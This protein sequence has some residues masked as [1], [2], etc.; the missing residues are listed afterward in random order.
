M[1]TNST[2]TRRYLA[3]AVLL[4]CF[5]FGAFVS[6]RS[7]SLGLGEKFQF[8]ASRVFSHA[9]WCHNVSTAKGTCTQVDALYP[10]SS[11]NADTWKELGE[12]LGT[13]KFKKL[14]IGK[15]SGLIQIP[16]ESYDN[17]PPP[18]EDPRWETMGQ[19]HDYL[20]EAFPRIHSTL[21]LT[22][23]NTYGLMYEWTGSDTSLK[24]YILAAHQDV[25]P[26]NP[27]T[28]DTWTHPPYSGYFDGTT[29]WGRGASDDKGSLAGIM[30][31]LETLIEKGWTPS[32][33]IVL[34]FGFDEEASGI[35]GASAL[36]KALEETYGRDAFAFVV[37]EGGGFKDMYG[38]IF[39]T[40]GVAEKGYIDVKVD[41][42]SPGGHSS[43]PP[44][45][46]TIGYLA[47]LIAE[48][49]K[50]PYPVELARNTVP[51]DTLLCYA[52]HGDTIPSSLKHAIIKSIHSD[53][54]LRKVDELFV[55][56]DLWYSSL[57]GTTQAV[58]IV[59]GGVKANALPESA[60]AIVNHRIN[61]VS[62]VNETTARDTQTIISLA[63]S[64]NLTLNAFGKDIIP[65][66][67]YSTPSSCQSSEVSKPTVRGH[68]ELSLAF[69]HE[70]EPAPRTPTSGEGSGPWDFLSGTI[71]ATYNAQ[72]GLEGNNHIV[73]SPGMSTGNTDTK[74]YWNL[75]RHIFRY[76]HKNGAYGGDV[77]TGIHTVNENIPLDHYLEIIRFF[78]TLIL[79]ADESDAFES[80]G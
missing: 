18:G 47:S 67:V 48:Y 60:Y 40:P 38:T 49:E 61:T 76:N 11:K 35:Y 28:V 45:H 8:A 29:I 4:P 32:R 15:L 53:K 3:C 69:N 73:V 12:Q 20:A 71:K 44:A 66:S 22:K 14:A 13:E 31:T 37:D 10:S 34:A 26:V 64:L 25:V 39:A 78:S 23:V 79:N 24:P 59:A 6:S 51:Y 9:S 80:S 30:L 58:D 33:T 62:S 63:R 65:A 43:V 17:M 75:T 19:V 7:S 72:R 1:R 50:N 54:A 56:K 68:I 74:Y 77:A 70:L 27:D 42:T 41:V 5:L 16:S 21:S 55:H 52:A 57:V 36:G 46:T 2:R